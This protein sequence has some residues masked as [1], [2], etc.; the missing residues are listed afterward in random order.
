MRVKCA[1]LAWHTLKAAL[2]QRSEGVDR[3]NASLPDDSR[4]MIPTADEPRQPTPDAET[5]HRRARRRSG[6]DRRAAA[7]D[8]RGVSRRCSTR[9]SRSNIWELGLI[10]DVFVDADGVA[11]IRMTLTAPGCPAAQIAAGRGRRRRSK[12][13]A[14]VTDAKVDVVWEP[15]LDK[16][17]MSDAGEAAAGDVVNARA[18]HVRDSPRKPTTR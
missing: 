8:Q 14:G 12:A 6:E 1:S 5:E 15:A 10:Y 7:G 9:R 3:M 2:A 13:V 11:A 16:D 18:R 4:Q 17:R